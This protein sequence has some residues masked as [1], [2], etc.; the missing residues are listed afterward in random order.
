MRILR[1]ERCKKPC[2]LTTLDDND[3]KFCPV[4]KESADWKLVNK[5]EK[6]AA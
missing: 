4:T 5:H 2:M 3:M 6:I 1:C